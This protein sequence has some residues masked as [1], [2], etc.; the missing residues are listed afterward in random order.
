ML[1]LWFT[2][3]APSCGCRVLLLEAGADHDNTPAIR[4]AKNAPS[5]EN[6]EALAK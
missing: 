3:V 6:M 2:V 4:Q 5:L 1:A